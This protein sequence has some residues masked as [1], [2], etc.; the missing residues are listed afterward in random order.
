M[1]IK[2]GQ[3]STFTARVDLLFFAIAAIALLPL[4]AA[5]QGLT[6]SLIGRVRDE[7]GAAIQGATVR[8]SSPALMGGPA[9]LLTNENGQLRFPVLPPGVVRTRHRDAGVCDLARQ[10]ILIAAGA[11]IERTAT[12]KL[13]GVEESIVVEGTGSRIDA[14]NPGFGT[15]FGSEDIDAI[16]TRRASMFDFVRAAP[17]VSPTSPSSGIATTISAFGSGTNEN[18]F[19]IDGMNTTCPCSGVARSEPGV[20]FIHEVQV[21]AVGAS[22]EFGNMQGARDQHRHQARQRAVLVR[23]VVLRTGVRAHQ[24]AGQPQV[25]R[26]GEQQSGYERA[27]YE[28]FTNNLGGPA[29]RD[30]LWFF[31]GYQ[32]LRD[33]D[34]QPGTD[35]TLPRTYEMQKLFAKLTWRLAPG[36]QLVQSFHDEIG[37]DPERPTIVTPFEATARTHISTPTMNFGDLTHTMSA[38]TLWDVRVGR[39]VSHRSGDLNA[40]S[41]TTPSRFD[42]VTGVTTGARPNSAAVDLFRTTA[43]A[44]LTH[45]RRALAAEHQLKVGGQFE[46]GEHHAINFIPTGVRYEDRAGQPFQSIS[47]LPANIGGVSLTSSAFATDTMTVRDRLTITA[48]VRFDHSRAISQDLPAVDADR[49]ET[50]AVIDGLGT[51]YT[52]NLWSPRLGVT[53]KLSADGRTILRASYGRFYQG[54]FTGELE[55][56]HPGAT[57]VT[58]VG[59][60]SA[61][62]DYSGAPITVDPKVNLQWDPA[63][64]APRTDEYSIGVD[65]AVGARLTV[66]IS[67]VR[68]DGSDFIGWTDVAGQYVEGTQTLAD[69]RSVTVYRLNTAVTPPAARRF[70]LTNP[71]GYSLTYNGVVVATEKRRS[72]GWQAFASYTWS[73]AYGLLPSSN[74]SAAGTQTSTVSP[75]Q[76][77]TFGRDPNDLTNARGR[78]A[79][80]SPA[81]RTADGQRGR[82]A[83]RVRAR[84]QP[85]AV[86]R[87][88]VDSRGADHA[89]ARRAARPARA[90]RLS[91]AVLTNP[92][93]SAFVEAD[94][95]GQARPD[96]SAAR[97]AQSAQRHGGRE[98]GDRDAD[99][100]DGVQSDVR[101]AGQLCGSAA[102]DARRQA[103]PG[104]IAFKFSRRFSA[105]WIGGKAQCQSER[106]PGFSCWCWRWGSLAASLE[107]CIASAFAIASAIGFQPIP[108]SRAHTDLERFPQACSV[109][110][111][112]LV[113]FSKSRRR[114]RRRSRASTC[115]ASCAARRLTRGRSRTPTGSIASP[116]CGPT[117]DVRTSALVRQRGL[118]RSARSP[119][120]FNE[121]GWR[122]VLVI[123]DTR[124]DVQLVRK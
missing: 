48:G 111:P 98:P 87:Q 14:R 76:P 53:T 97:C 59:F 78:L 61:T 41:P 124:F 18:Q 30:R 112:S 11:T 19:L 96:R 1:R 66:S 36:W 9:T 23:R 81:R 55:P 115:I 120:L 51:M 12:L 65:R 85:P 52:W 113:W 71:D 25:S 50:D 63:M 72:N 3:A 21:S 114:A 62:G 32:W 28:D 99:D 93:R 7:Q 16:P 109:T 88:A 95:V 57:P 38:N 47:S 44:T 33:Y 8:L 39:F 84:G 64:R 91:P 104:S 123:G 92:A 70:L 20:D 86:Q 10:D 101:S 17:G 40:L 2:T 35:P 42:R 119:T 29:I 60:N 27:K 24:P 13:A 58:M 45:Y 22:A 108:A 56:F 26:L 89:A 68:K 15:R 94:H 103:E 110:T 122:Q 105:S 116:G 49:H 69:G 74:A 83:N 5:A 73:K 75:P 106:Q 31:A 102:R 46:R 6:G 107:V 34:S 80:R 117:P 67:Y 37:I 4:V 77:S 79:Q 82:T 54:V 118:H 43:K 121:P 100:G 90:T